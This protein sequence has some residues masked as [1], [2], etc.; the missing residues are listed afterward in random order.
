LQQPGT[1]ISAVKNIEETI[2]PE[3]R[4]LRGVPGVGAA[5][6]EPPGEIKSGIKIW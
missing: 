1:H 3:H 4:F 5:A 6:Q 2:R